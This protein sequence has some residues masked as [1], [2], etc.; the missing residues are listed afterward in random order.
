MLFGM[1]LLFG[2]TGSVMLADFV[3][4][5]AG[6]QSAVLDGRRACS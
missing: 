4:P 3:E 6:D 5:G 1:A 2:A